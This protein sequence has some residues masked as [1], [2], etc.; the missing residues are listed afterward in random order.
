MDSAKEKM[1]VY[2]ESID[3]LT[4]GW[5][6]DRPPIKDANFFDCNEGWYPLIQRLIEDL[7]DLGWDKQVTQVKEKFGGLRFYVNSCSTEMLDRIS[8]A[9]RESYT[10]CE[11]C[12]ASGEVRRD[13]VWH[14]TLCDA[15]YQQNKNERV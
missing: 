3:G 9:E 1:D 6:P 2:L 15:H 4:N 12:G 13:L 5:R 14:S 10:I 11:N 7:I 8:E